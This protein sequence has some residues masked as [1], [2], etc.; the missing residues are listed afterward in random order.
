VFKE[1]MET[2]VFKKLSL[3]YTYGIG[4][5]YTE[6]DIGKIRNSRSFDRE[7]NLKFSGGQ[8]NVIAPLAIDRVLKLGEAMSDT[9]DNWNIETKYCLSLD[10]GWG[11][12]AFAIILSR[13]IN[14]KVQILYA[15]EFER[16][17]FQD[18]IDK[19][20]QIKRRCASLQNIIMDS[21]NTEIYTALCSDFNQN[22][23]LQYLRDK[24]EHCRKNN[25][26][27]EDYLFIS[28]VPFSI[29]GQQMLS[30]CKW[31][32]EQTDDNGNAVVSIDKRF[33]KLITSMR[34]AQETENR[35]DKDATVH[36]DLFDALRLNCYWYK[37]RR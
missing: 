3:D 8:G 21:A 6:L 24:Q 2:S 12:S 23:S 10:P 25:L 27:L 33:D 13:Y 5:I 37:R 11:S 16:P 29:Y 19:I 15:D 30:H 28:P 35:L 9:L 32:V 26:N 17:L 36:D 4:K 34:T 7:F 14:G 1:P 22:S 20:W 18:I 31:M